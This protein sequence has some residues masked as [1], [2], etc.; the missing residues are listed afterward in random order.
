[1]YKEAE[2]ARGLNLKY[3][4]RLK[5]LCVRSQGRLCKRTW[6]I[7][8]WA[9]FR[10][11][12]GQDRLAR[13]ASESLFLTVVTLKRFRGLNLDILIQNISRISDK[14]FA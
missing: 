6:E 7:S 2:K 9:H 13:N 11:F 14:N 12:Q 10:D 1:M 3:L 8:S 5:S 4:I